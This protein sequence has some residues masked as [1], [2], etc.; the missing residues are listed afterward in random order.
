[1]HHFPTSKRSIV[2]ALAF[3]VILL[4]STATDLSEAKS[5]FLH[6]LESSHIRHIVNVDVNRDAQ[7]NRDGQIAVVFTVA[8]PPPLPKH[9]RRRRRQH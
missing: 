3:L 4:A 6:K 1:M 7:P 5:I 2:T 9:R 8:R